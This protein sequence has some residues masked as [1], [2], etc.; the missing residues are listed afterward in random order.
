MC[1]KLTQSLSSFVSCVYDGLVREQL[2][3]FNSCLSFL[4]VSRWK[5]LTETKIKWSDFI[6]VKKQNK[7][8]NKPSPNKY[9]IEIHTRYVRRRPLIRWTRLCGTTFVGVICCC[10][11]DDGW[12]HNLLCQLILLLPFWLVYIYRE[13]GNEKGKSKPHAHSR[14]ISNYWPKENWVD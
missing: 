6:V 4:L 9:V 1:V 13:R 12:S 10:K 7:K 2:G 3:S 11:D 8:N 14:K 5:R